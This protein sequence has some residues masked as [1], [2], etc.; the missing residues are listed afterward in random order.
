MRERCHCLIAV[1][2]SF[3]F[4]EEIERFERTGIEIAEVPA[5]HETMQACAAQIIRFTEQIRNHRQGADRCQ[6]MRCSQLIFRHDC[7]SMPFCRL[8]DFQKLLGGTGISQRI[9]ID[10]NAVRPNASTLK[11][12]HQSNILRQTRNNGFTRRIGIH[13]P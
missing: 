10:A 7:D 12:H 13:G 1:R 5:A 6:F 11:I 9:F 2:F 3:Q 8:S 4:K